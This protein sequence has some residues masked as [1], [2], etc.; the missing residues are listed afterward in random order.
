MAFENLR[1]RKVRTFLTLIGIF[2]GIAAVVALVS[3]AQGFQNY[4]DAEF[5]EL[6]A[7]KIIIN[8]AGSSFGLNDRTPDP[9]TKD[10]VATISAVK[11]VK[12]VSSYSF[13]V[14]TVKWGRDDQT[15]ATIITYPLD[16]NRNLLEEITTATILQGRKLKNT[17]G[18]KA[19][20]GYDYLTANRF[21]EN[22]ITGKKITIEGKEFEIVGINDKIGSQQ[23]DESVF[24]T[25]NAYF[26]IYPDEDKNDVGA[27]FARVHEGE[28]P[29]DIVK[30]I[31]KDLRK[32]R[33][34]KEGEEDFE[35]TTF[36]DLIQSF[37]NIFNIVQV[38]LIGIAG[39]S[40]V[41]GGIGIMNTMYTAVLERTKDIGIMKAIGAKNSDVLL[42][43]VIESGFLGLMGGVLGVLIGA[44]LAK[45]VEYLGTNAF[46]T[47]LLKAAL[48]WWL[49]AGALGFAFLLGSLFGTL[50][51]RRASKMN[52]VD[53]LR[54]E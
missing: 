9:L 18:F 51:A 34:V 22:L 15:F 14:S 31:E 16:E 41:V 2:V 3:L 48:P 20:V 7:D 17:D 35:V 1:H 32:Q 46:G 54:T 38:V 10:D 36:E 23:D 12:E 25:E 43:F 49:I 6:G 26:D 19:V 4:L 27:I 44:G 52:P 21:S 8:P 47:E 29:A 39:I 33:D 50:P 30:K 5:K 45:A 42:I 37:L 24:I 40:L 13:Q 11:G 28:A 53:A